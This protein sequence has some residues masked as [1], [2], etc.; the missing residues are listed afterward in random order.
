MSRESLDVIIRVRTDKII[1]AEKNVDRLVSELAE[2][3]VELAAART[4]LVD[5]VAEHVGGKR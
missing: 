1:N 5:A 4:A 2:A 3:V